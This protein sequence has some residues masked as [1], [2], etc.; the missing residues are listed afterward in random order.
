M[1]T[2]PLSFTVT[3][4]GRTFPLNL[5]P[6]YPISE[7]SIHLEE[8]TGVPPSLQKLLYKGKKS[9][10]NDEATIDDVGIK[11]GVKVQ[12]LGSTTEEIGGMKAVEDEQQR[13]DRVMRERA[14]KVPTK[15]HIC[16][17]SA[18]F[19]LCTDNLTAPIDG[20]IQ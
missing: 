10:P 4:R 5:L 9:P 6:T 3:H 13:R 12:M 1:S 7:L 8:L 18:P 20:C 17:A 11:G 19:L 14:S 2:S 16:F 15:V